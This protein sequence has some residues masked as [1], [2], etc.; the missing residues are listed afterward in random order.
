[1]LDKL[2][3]NAD[4]IVEIMGIAKP[5]AYQLIRNLNKELKEKGYMVIRGKV[6]TQYFYERCGITEAAK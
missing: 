2:F 5:T 1:M 6:S 3:I 4:E